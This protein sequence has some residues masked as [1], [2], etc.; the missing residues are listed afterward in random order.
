MKVSRLIQLPCEILELIS[1][2]L[3]K[4]EDI[5][6]LRLVC[7]ETNKKFRNAFAARHFRTAPVTLAI[8][9]LHRLEEFE[10]HQLSANAV[11]TLS[12]WPSYFVNPASRSQWKHRM[13]CE[14]KTEEEKC[15]VQKF[16]TD[17]QARLAA[18]QTLIDMGR[19]SPKLAKA[20]K[21]MEKL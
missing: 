16:Y 12:I 20:L 4:Q 7:R 21:C 1:E 10:R 14:S 11:R 17:C 8:S 15:R 5:G 6:V 2:H 18:Q 19:E 13:Y 3:E 9:G